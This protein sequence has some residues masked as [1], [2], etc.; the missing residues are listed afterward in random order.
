M[1]KLKPP[2]NC[3]KMCGNM[4]EIVAFRKVVNIEDKVIPLAHCEGLMN[5][6]LI[7]VPE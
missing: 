7:A 3:D 2:C 4:E 1:M 6:L 5:D